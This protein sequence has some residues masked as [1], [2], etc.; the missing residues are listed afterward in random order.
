MEPGASPFDDFRAASRATP[1]ASQPLLLESMRPYMHQMVP[2]GR[3]TPP[4][5]PNP[6]R[7]RIP[8][9]PMPTGC[10]NGKKIQMYQL[11]F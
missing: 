9:K 10:T 5:P 4:E 8:P 1:I 3:D 2:A 6:D 11:T 7:S